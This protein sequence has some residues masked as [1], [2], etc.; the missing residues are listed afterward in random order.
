MLVLPGGR[1]LVRPKDLSL[2]GICILVPDQVPVG[3][4]CMIGLETL[5][6]GNTVR[7]TASATVVYS[8]LSGVDGFRTGLEFGK[9][10]AANDRLLAELLI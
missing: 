9:L 8:I 5:M 6:N 1:L 7:F 4:T 10:D 2:G 3:Q